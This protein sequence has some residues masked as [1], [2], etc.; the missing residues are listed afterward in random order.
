MIIGKNDATKEFKVYFT[1]ERI[2]ITAQHI[3]NADTLNSEEIAQL[4][5]QLEHEAPE[6]RRALM[7]RDEAA[8]QKESAAGLPFQVTTP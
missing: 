7:T 1:E 4:Q 8:K 6:L 3:R 2:F 5:A